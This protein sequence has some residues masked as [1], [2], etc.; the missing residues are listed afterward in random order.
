MGKK[1][2][3]VAYKDIF[4]VGLV[5]NLTFVLNFGKLQ[6]YKVTKLF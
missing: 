4:F 1:I 6:S 3:L 2:F 5:L